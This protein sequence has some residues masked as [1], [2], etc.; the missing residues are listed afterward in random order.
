MNANGPQYVPRAQ[1]FLLPSWILYRPAGEVRWREGRTE[2]I[3]QSGVLFH[4]MEPIDVQIPVEV[5]MD[6][7]AQLL[8]TPGGASLGRGRNVRHQTERSDARPAFAAAISDWEV[9]NVDP[10]RI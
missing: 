8:G 1:R 6:L 10:R 7:P 5:M 2:N 3:S 4:G 9:L